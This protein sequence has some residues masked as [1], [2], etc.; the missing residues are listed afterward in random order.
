VFVVLVEQL[1][2]TI[3]SSSCE[4]SRLKLFNCDK[5]EVGYCEQFA[6]AKYDAGNSLVML[7]SGFV[8]RLI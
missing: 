2:I 3:K 6:Y 1:F 7:R 4:L 8:V 5:S